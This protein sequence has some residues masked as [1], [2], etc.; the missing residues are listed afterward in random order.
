M[1]IKGN[2][3]IEKR[4]KNKYR[5]RF[6]LGYDPEAEKYIHTPWRTVNGTKEDARREKE[7]YRRELENGLSL[8]LEKA[9]FSEYADA[10]HETRSALEG[11]AI[12]TVD[13]EKYQIALLVRYLGDIRMRDINPNTVKSAFV[14]LVKDD[15]ISQTRLHDITVKAKH[16]FECAVDDGAILVSPMR[17]IKAPKRSKPNRNSLKPSKARSLLDILDSSELSRNIVAV[18]IGLATGLRRGEVLALR[19]CNIDLDKLVIR[20]THGIDK[21]GN[22]KDTKTDAGTR[23]LAI[24]RHTADKLAAWKT[25]QAAMLRAYGVVQT[26]DTFVC[27]TNTGGACSPDRFSKWF[28]SFC[29]KNHFAIYVDEQGNPLPEYRCNENG[30]EVDEQGKPFSRVNKK[31]TTKKYYSGLK[32]H[33]LRHTQATLLLANGA[34]INTVQ[35]RLGHADA[36]TTINIYGHALPEQDREAARLFSS[37]LAS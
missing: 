8:D 13:T 33:E 5:V 37:L 21:Y 9:T 31:P 11:L 12:S 3:T 24:D 18:Y 7:N 25:I 1:K 16:I 17:R 19:W 35:E 27:G 26:D 20:V 4:G 10:F 29:I 32:F 14:K 23:N 2:G 30:V 15:G 6:N 34:P 28:R 22:L 36:S